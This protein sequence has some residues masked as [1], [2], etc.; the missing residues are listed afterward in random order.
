MIRIKKYDFLHIQIITDD[1][2]YLAD[3]KEFFTDWVEGYRFMAKFRQGGWSGKIS[4]MASNNTLPF[5]LLFDV[6]RFTRQNYKNA[7]LTIDGDVKKFFTGDT[8]PDIEYNLNIWPRDYQIDCIETGLKYKRC[9]MRVATAGGKSL[10]I[11]YIIKALLDDYKIKRAIIIVPTQSLVEQFYKDMKDYGMNCNSIGRVY[12]KIKEYN[13]QIV[14]STWQSLS[15][16]LD[17]IEDFDCIVC[18]EVHGVKGVELRKILSRAINAD[19]RIGVTGTLPVT[20]LDMFNVKGF[21]GP[22]VKEYGSAE[23]AE[24]GYISHCNI[25]Y[26]NI[27]YNNPERYSGEYNDIKDKI[28]NNLNRMKYIK[29]I[30]KNADSNILLLVGKVESEGKILQEYLG[31]IKGK[32]IV[33][34]WGNTPVAEREQWRAEC[35]KRKNI[36]LIATYGILQVGVNIPSLKYILFASPFKSKIR[37]LQSIGRALRKHET[38]DVAVIYDLADDVQYLADHSMRRLRYYKS[39]KFTVEET[40]I[41]ENVLSL[42]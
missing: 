31:K 40:T 13:K 14:I 8:E 35:E 7:E 23:L 16:K 25:K 36:I 38:K 22:V 10:I 18:D 6:I 42:T 29:N 34:I 24:Q 19:Y 12:S 26:T 33:F 21:I 28:F 1:R 5:G 3:L 17:W 27:G 2:A 11:S 39:E 9:I 37:V 32:E 30:V 4:V 41:H 15:R 20:K